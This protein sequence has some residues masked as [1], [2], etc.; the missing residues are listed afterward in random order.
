MN[1]MLLFLNLMFSLNKNLFFEKFSFL[2]SSSPKRNTIGYGIW[3]VLKDHVFSWACLFLL[4]KI[5]NHAGFS[6]ILLT[7][8]L[9]VKLLRIDNIDWKLYF[10]DDFRLA[11]PEPRKRFLTVLWGN[12]AK[13]LLFEDFTPLYILAF[14]LFTPLSPLAAT[15]FYLFFIALFAFILTYFFLL[16][17]GSLGI[18]KLYS[19][20]SYLFSMVSTFLILHVFL[21]VLITLVRSID[22]TVFKEDPMHVINAI[23]ADATAVADGILGWTTAAQG[24]LMVALPVIALALLVPVVYV[25]ARREQE[26]CAYDD[27]ALL[28]PKLLERSSSLF[29]KNPVHK[30]FFTKELQMFSYLYRYNFKQYWFA[31]C[32]DRSAATLLAVWLAL[33]RFDIPNGG[34]IFFCMALIMMTL[35][36]SSQVGV[37]MITNISFISDFNTLRVANTNGLELKDMVSAKL[38]FFYSVRLLP[39]IAFGV[40]C[41][42]CMLTLD[43]PVYTVC[44][45]A[46]SFAFIIWIYPSVYLTNNLISTKM[47]YRDYEKYLEES[48]ILDSGVE[49]F[50]PLSI[51]Y[52][53]KVVLLLACVLTAVLLPNVGWVY[54]VTGGAMLVLGLLDHLIMK[55]VLSNILLFIQG[56]DYSADIKKIFRRAGTSR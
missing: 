31:V 3:F 27:N 41:A 48:K 50:M 36:I 35:D 12:L 54:G 9:L 21:N 4:L 13:S 20:L 47:D 17:T 25:L 56:G 29:C 18:K 15:V 49:D 44:M 23:Q 55:R 30:A 51:T 26:P 45:L 32:L 19:F 7:A 14:V 6:L 40:I 39:M 33:Y 52:K 28:F 37:K 43:A 24:W 34:L 38:R 5:L 46:V 8:L 2:K 16:E 42:V 10:R 22:F 53:I 11:C 1:Q